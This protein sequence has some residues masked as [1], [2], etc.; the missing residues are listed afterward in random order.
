MFAKRVRLGLGLRPVLAPMWSGDSG[1]SCINPI[2]NFA[3]SRLLSLCY[4]N[5]DKPK[6][7]M[8]DGL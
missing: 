5:A 3:V 4:E 2:K 7:M 6:A 1:Y 8:M